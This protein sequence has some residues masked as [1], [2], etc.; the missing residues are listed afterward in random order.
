LGGAEEVG[1]SCSLVEIDGLRLLVDCG[2]RLRAEAGCAL[3]DFSMI[4]IGRSVDAILITHAHADHIGAL[5]ALEPFLGDECRT[6]A[7]SATINLTKEMLQ[8]SVRIMTRF[9]RDE[10]KI[11][12]FP[13]GN[14]NPTLARFEAVA[15]YKP[16]ALG[17]GVFATWYPAGHILGAA[18]VEIRGPSGSILFSG[19]ISVADQLSVP[20]VVAPPIRPNILVLESTYGGRLHAHRPAQERRL[21]ERV[22][23]TIAA[24]GSVLFPTFALGR[25]QEV[26]LLLGRAMR[27]GSMPITP[28]YADGLV[29]AVSKVYSRLHEDLSPMCRRLYEDGLDPIFPEDLPIRPIKNDTHRQTVIKGPPCVAV[30]SSGMLQGGASAIYGAHWIRDPENLIVLTGFQ[31]EESPGQALLNLAAAETDQA[32]YFKLAGV[33]TEVRCQVESCWLSAHADNGE[34]VAFASK[35]S[36]QLILPVHGDGQARESLAHSLLAS[37]KSQVVIPMNGGAY[38][39]DSVE[40]L[41]HQ[42]ERLRVDPLSFWPPWDPSQERPLDLEKFHHWLWNLPS[43][44]AWLTL[45]E[46]MELW[47]SPK[48]PTGAEWEE[49]RRSV[50]LDSQPYFIPDAKRPYIL[51]LAHPDNIASFTRVE[52]LPIPQTETL[53]YEVFPDSSYFKRVGFFPKSGEVQL[54]FSFLSVLKDR[55]ARRVAEFAEQCGWTP[56]LVDRTESKDVERVL[57]QHL[58][59]PL[60]PTVVCL[61]DAMVIVDGPIPTDETTIVKRFHERT[62]FR[63]HWT[64]NNRDEN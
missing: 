38:G 32:R 40:I 48:T 60:P 12:L 9:R 63:L 37:L 24:G 28:V 49:L 8:D 15:W 47:L 21:V 16:I 57:A 45:D 1:A 10:G 4:E 35:L 6:F 56:V 29:R 36:P 7:T 62:G 58:E 14:L 42:R 34:L 11:P 25:T 55:L 5:P 50:Y 43:R 3:P 13:Q 59:S 20:G 31:D 22:K 54:E 19:D 30:A 18:M 26:L 2:Q 39:L 51:H 61:D 44:T 41:P 23:E 52:R 64:T 46:L 53:A 17:N 33:M 27:D